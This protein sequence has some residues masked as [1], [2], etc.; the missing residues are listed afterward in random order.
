MELAGRQRLCLP[1][2]LVSWSH[3]FPLLT[4]VPS[5]LI[6]V[7]SSFI[8]PGPKAPGRGQEHTSTQIY[9][10]HLPLLPSGEISTMHGGC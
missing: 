5:P 8:A 1:E 4:L 9:L 7:P 6:A 10:H 3:S 2:L